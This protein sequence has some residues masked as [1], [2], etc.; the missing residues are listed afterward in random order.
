VYE[1][2]GK[3]IALPESLFSP[4]KQYIVYSSI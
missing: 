2:L 3:E 1:E 4:S